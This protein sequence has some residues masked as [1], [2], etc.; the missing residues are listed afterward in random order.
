ME[1]RTAVVIDQVTDNTSNSDDKRSGYVKDSSSRVTNIANAFGLDALLQKD[2]PQKTLL[3]RA[4][5]RDQH[6]HEQRQKNLEQILKFA[7]DSC[8]DEAAGDPDLDWLYRFFDMAQ[9]INNSS[10]QRLWAQVLKLEI[11]NPGSTSMKALQVLKDMTPKEAQTLQ[12]AAS[13]A[14]SF[15][16]DHSKKLLLGFKTAARLFS[17]SKRDITNT[18]NLGNH[19]LPYSSLLLLIELGILLSTELESGEIGFEPALSLSYQG[20]NIELQPMSKGAK[21][22][23]YRFSPVGNELCR[24]LGN[25]PNMSYYDQMVALLGQK[26]SLQTDVKSTVNHLV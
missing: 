6:R 26:F 16:N 18:L 15:G 9:D 8:K 22:I 20:K 2:P 12:R 1:R 3:E 14:C 23:Y 21:L 13:L 25:R 10:M 4:A 11:T 19:Q 17:I 5:L 24:L 7:F